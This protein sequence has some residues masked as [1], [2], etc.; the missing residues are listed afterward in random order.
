M[1]KMVIIHKLFLFV[2]V[3]LLSVSCKTKEQT[4]NFY[5]PH[6]DQTKTQYVKT[7]N[8]KTAELDTVVMIRSNLRDHVFLFSD[9]II[10]EEEFYIESGELAVPLE[11]INSKPP[12]F[13]TLLVAANYLFSTDFIDVL[14]PILPDTLADQFF[15]SSQADSVDYSMNVDSEQTIGSI[16]QLKK[17]ETRKA[18]LSVP[19][20]L[21]D[22]TRDLYE[23]DSILHTIIGDAPWQIGDS[24]PYFDGMSNLFLDSALMLVFDTLRIRVFDPTDIIPQMSFSVLSDT[25][26][27]TIQL[28]DTLFYTN[29]VTIRIFYPDEIDLFVDMVRVQ[30]GTFKIGSNEFDDDERPEYNLRVSNFLL[31]KYEITNYHFVFF[32]NDIECDSLGEIDGLKIID[33]EHPL[34]RIERNRFTGKFSVKYGWDDFPVAN[35]TWVGAQMFCKAAGGRLPSEAE[36]EYAARGGIYAV[37][38]YTDLKKENFNYEFRYAGGHYMRELGWFVDNSRGEV[39]VG[40][41]LKPNELGLYDMCGNLWE[42]CYDKYNNEFYRHNNRSNDPM[43]LSGS[44]IRVNRGGSWSSDAMFCRVTNRNFLNQFQSN[45]YLGFRL[46]REWK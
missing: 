27:D 12:K 16:E 40:G 2:A 26:I 32:L 19:E 1:P 42:W 21:A 31:G 14:F 41:R 10:I 20:I 45:P 37:R 11:L 7:P 5:R 44:D 17:A 22:S 8:V 36:W 34:T 4:A 29:E 43:N 18:F 38:Y 6:F 23:A 35:V 15:K 30:G 39:S 13:D 46:M 28:V 9:T 24:I 25:R 3:V 33:L